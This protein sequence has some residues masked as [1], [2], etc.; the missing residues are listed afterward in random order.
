MRNKKIKLVIGASSVGK[1]TYIEHIL[2]KDKL[3]V[4]L[5]SELNR[6]DG[7][8][9]NCIIHYN[10][11]RPYNNSI[12]A[13]NNEFLDDP[14]L[15]IILEEKNDLSVDFLVV[16]KS[17][18][19]K[20]VLLRRNIE[21]YLRKSNDQIYPTDQFINLVCELDHI[22]FYEKWFS[23]FED[24]NLPFKLI[25]STSLQFSELTEIEQARNLIRKNQKEKYSKEEVQKILNKFQFGYQKIDLPYGLSTSG[26]SRQSSL[27]VIFNDDLENKSLLDVGCAYGYF[28]F[29][30]EKR[31]AKDIVG[32]ELKNERYIGANIIKEIIGSDAIFVKTDVIFET[33][34]R[35]FDIV[36]LLNVIHHLKYPIYALKM[37]S[38]LCNE[39]MIIEFPTVADKKFQSTLESHMNNEQIP[40]VGVSSYKDCDQT[41]LFNDEAIRRILMD[42]NQFF[43]KVEFYESP[44]EKDRRIAFC[45]K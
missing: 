32:T 18:H 3:P 20:R 41:F 12:E 7:I 30:A 28:S 4:I 14:A 17:T 37:L 35:K 29:E 22:I 31:K 8:N 23:F 38:E 10:S 26:Q 11:F 15:N 45:Y 13:V 27:D 39:K 16:N 1:S 24:H 9:E 19:L 6:K 42:H 36:L 43:N 25:D 33:I 5:A 21:P 2:R 40:L 44:F 34:N